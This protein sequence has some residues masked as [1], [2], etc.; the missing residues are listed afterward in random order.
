MTSTMIDIEDKKA[1]KNFKMVLLSREEDRV[2]SFHPSEASQ[3]RC[4][5]NPERRE[6]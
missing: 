6:Y 2:K 1:R 4:N 5:Y 3:Q